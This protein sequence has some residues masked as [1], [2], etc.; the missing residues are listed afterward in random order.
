MGC[1][2]GKSGSRGGARKTQKTFIRQGGTKSSPR[3]GKRKARRA[4]TKRG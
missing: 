3:A 2:S 1:C 4:L